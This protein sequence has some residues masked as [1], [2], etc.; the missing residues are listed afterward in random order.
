MLV[1]RSDN[2]LLANTASFLAAED[3]VRCGTLSRIICKLHFSAVCL[4]EFC[5]VC[6]DCR[7]SVHVRIRLPKF[8]ICQKTAS[9]CYIRYGDLIGSILAIVQNTRLM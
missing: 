7:N 4:S 3:V 8:D 5:A 1:D 2:Y 6:A 9:R